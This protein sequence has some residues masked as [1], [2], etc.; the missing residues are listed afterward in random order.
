MKEI[1]LSQGKVALVDDEDFEFLNQ[2]K[3]Y[4]KKANRTFYALRNSFYVEN[5]KRHTIQMHR[6]ILGLK[7]LNIKCDHIDHN[8]L[9]NQKNNLRHS[10]NAENCKNQKPKEG[11]SSIYKG[12]CWCNKRK[13]WRANIRINDRQKHIGYFKDEIECA[14]AYDNMAKIH[15][16]EFAYLNFPD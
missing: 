14:K 9:N 15:Y 13:K 1:K 7:D 8:G 16:K 2:F 5:K 11:Y 3:W 12:V 4:A 10:T 6:V